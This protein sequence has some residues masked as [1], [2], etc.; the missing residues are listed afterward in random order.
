[1]L[2]LAAL[3]LPRAH[4]L[5]ALSDWIQL[6]L[7]LSGTL[8]FIPNA[9]R[10]HGR[11]R[12]F[13]ALLAAGMALW[14]LYQAM[15]IYFEVFLHQEVPD[16]FAG[17]IV[18]F[19]HIV[20]MMAALALR[21]HAPQDEYSSNLRRLDFAL[22]IFWW[23]YLYVFAVMAWQYVVPNTDAYGDN[24]NFLYAVEKIAFLAALVVAWI[25]SKSGDGWKTF[26]AN[27]FGASLTYAASSYVANWALTHHLYYSGSLYDIPLAVSM[28]WITLT[29]LWCGGCEPLSSRSGSASHGVWLARLGMIT[30]FSL[31]IFAGWAWLLPGDPH[32]RSFRLVLTLGAAL[33]M[34]GMIFV[35]QTFL[36]RELLRLLQQSRDSF[37]N[38]KRLQAQ[39]MESEKLAS[40][41]KL[42]GGAAHELNNPITAMLGYSDL[43]VN[44]S[45]NGQQQALA[46]RIGQQIRRT[47]SLV[48]SLLSF[49]KQSPAAMA[50][51]NITTLLRTAVRL[52]QPQWKSLNLEIDTDFAPAM[53]AVLG[54]SNQLLQVCVQILNSAIH[55]T[56]QQESL[57]RESRNF[58]SAAQESTRTRTRTLTITCEL[59]NSSALIHVF[60]PSLVTYELASRLIDDPGETPCPDIANPIRGLGLSACQGILKQHQGSI[61]AQQNK[62]KGFVLRMELPVIPAPPVQSPDAPVPVMWQTQPFS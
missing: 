13:W 12:A 26:Y 55:A 9:V 61:A 8:A 51:V 62:I 54:D 1:M 22:L 53:P 40:I 34:G 36:D 29:A 50:P 7:L 48:A 58:E 32:I 10:S 44:T 47:K 16:I 46:A 19:L 24:L 20:P 49:A 37:D 52:S 59:R 18:V 38:L 21:P 28:L 43:L 60:N 35:R 6:F 41:G 23:V 31:P 2:V 27:L 15:W 17:D 5:T 30:V 3:A 39:I 4:D 25:G 14:F 56:I 42:V 45:M 33:V 11:G 57:E